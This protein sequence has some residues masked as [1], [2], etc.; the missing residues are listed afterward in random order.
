[1]PRICEVKRQVYVPSPHT[2]VAACV[3]VR[4][5]G[6]GPRREETLA[7]QGS[8][9]WADTIRSR[10]SADNGKTWSPWQLVHRE[11]PSQGDCTKEESPSCSCYDP[12]SGKTVQMVFQRVL[13]GDPRNALDQAWKG[14]QLYFDHGFY[15]FSGDDGRTWG[16]LRQFKYEDGPSF[17]PANWRV[18]EFLKSNRMY[19]GYNAIALA[20]GSI[21]YPAVVPVPYRDDEDD[22]VVGHIPNLAEEG[23]VGGILCFIGRWDA[24]RADYEW[25]ASPPVFVPRRVSTRGLMEP[26]IVELANGDLL[27]EMRGSN[28]QMDP[29]VIPGRKWMSVSQDGGRTWS[30]VAD[31]RYDTGEQFYAPST[32]A[33]MV[34]SAKTGKLYWVGNICDASPEGNSP[35]YPLYIAE[36]DETIPALKRDTL[37][38][39]DDRD[40]ARDSE[41]L[42]L[43]NFSLLENRE[44]YELELYLTR[45]GEN[46]TGDD[47]WTANAY[48]YT[49]TL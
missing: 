20:N 30:E 25:A 38:V 15:Q 33:R 18:P 12:V 23:C 32:F 39:I 13:L 7:N 6:K 43:S 34:R 45:L 44:T 8:S 49:V 26:A 27:L 4:Y 47:I 29:N 5:V 11:W 41:V 1:M 31:L 14:E 37:T 2:R 9:D 22:K 46:G 40:P 17:D 42:Q 19:G 35:R 10:T 24:E 21:V 36:I 28:W 16:E 48:K 3:G